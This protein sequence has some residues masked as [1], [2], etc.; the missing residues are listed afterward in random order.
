MG[1]TPEARQ[2]R[3]DRIEGLLLEGKISE[4]TYLELQ[5]KHGGGP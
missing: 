5:K 3:L 2:S 4:A 1:E